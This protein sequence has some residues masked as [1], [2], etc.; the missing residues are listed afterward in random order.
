MSIHGVKGETYDAV[1]IYVKSRTGK[2]LTKKLKEYKRFPVD[3][4][5][6]EYIYFIKIH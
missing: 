5:D 3:K 2:M 1:L 4:G 6:Y